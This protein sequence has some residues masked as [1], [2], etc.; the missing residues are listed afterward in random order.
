FYP[1]QADETKAELLVRERL[2]G[3]SVLGVPSAELEDMLATAR[4]DVL[5]QENLAVLDKLDGQAFIP[6]S[7]VR[8]GDKIEAV[9]MDCANV[10]IPESS[11]LGWGGTYLPE[12][13]LTAPDVVRGVALMGS[14]QYLYQNNDVVALSMTQYAN[15]KVHTDL[16]LFKIDAED[17]LSYTASGAVPGHLLNQFSVDEQQGTVRVVSN[18]DSK[19]QLSMLQVENDELK[20]VGSVSD[21]APGEDVYAVRYVGNTAYVVTFRR[22]DPLFVF[23]VSDPKAPALLGEVEIPGFSQYIHPIGEDH[24]LTVGVRD[25]FNGVALRLFDVSDKTKPTLAF[26]HN[27]SPDES[28]SASYD[29]RA[30]AYFAAQGKLAIPVSSYGWSQDYCGYISTGKLAL[31]DVST[32]NGITPAGAVSTLPLV[33]AL[34]DANECGGYYNAQWATT[35]ERGTFIGDN[36]YAVARG[37]IVSAKTSNPDVTIAAAAVAVECDFGDG[38]FGG[39]S[40]SASA[41]AGVA[42]GAGGAFSDDM[43]QEV[44]V[45]GGVAPM[46]TM[47]TP[48]WEDVP[49]GGSGSYCDPYY[50]PGMGAGGSPWEGT[51][52][53]AGGGATG[54]MEVIGA[55]GA[56][57]S[58]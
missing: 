24:L 28:S 43:A 57:G 8:N 46:P 26:T 15:D 5:K 7:Y 6:E 20:I 10:Y 9:P 42:I 39:A 25:D 29:H 50:G 52:G 14:S 49:A 48:P 53:A 36:V 51:G 2:D 27:L 22:I 45:D 55:G 32:S 56:G 38:G 33:Q 1:T 44:D 19:T 37:G 3:K 47:I 18:L 54:G 40:G 13:D 30:F 12:L 17:T 11:D 35:P 23:D 31:F 21:I 16:H 4:V 41:D 34:S 58:F